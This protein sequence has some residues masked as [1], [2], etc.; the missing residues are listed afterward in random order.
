MATV[1]DRLN[2]WYGAKGRVLAQASPVSVIGN[3]SGPVIG[4]VPVKQLFHGQGQGLEYLALFRRGD[5]LEGVNVVGVHREEAH[6]FVHAL[7]HAS[8]E[9]GERGEMLPYFHLLFTGL[10][11]QTLG[12]HELDIFAGDEDLLEAVLHPANALGHEGEAVTVENGFLDTGDKAKTQVLADLADLPQK[13]QVKDKFLVL[14]RAQI[15][16]QLVHH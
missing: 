14:A 11:E 13:V 6:E 8:V 2:L 7:V 1:D 5:S 12:H 10:L 15:V 16:K 3:Q 4:N 9:L